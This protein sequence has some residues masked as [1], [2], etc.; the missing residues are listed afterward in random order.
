MEV[1]T[2]VRMPIDHPALEGHFPGRPIMPGVL[3]L[4]A[5]V[6]AAQSRFAVAELSVVPRAKFLR[7]IAGGA[8]VTIRLR[9]SPP[10]RIAYEARVGTEIVS[11]GDLEFKPAVPGDG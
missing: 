2:S 11:A 8:E 1:V 3:L 4:D 5:I 6:R 9:L 10:R 7:P